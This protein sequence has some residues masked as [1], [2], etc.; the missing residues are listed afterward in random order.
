[1]FSHYSCY[2][3]LI[4]LSQTLKYGIMLPDYRIPVEIMGK[5]QHPGPVEVVA[6]LA[7]R[8]PSAGST[9]GA[10]NCC[11]EMIIQGQHTQIILVTAADFL[12]C[13]SSF[14]PKKIVFR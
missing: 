11:M 2:L 10:E 7:H 9:A 8:L 1:M 14:Q 6:E 12:S 5:A 13:Q 3:F 4:A